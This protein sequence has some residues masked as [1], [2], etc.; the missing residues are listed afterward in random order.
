MFRRLFPCCFLVSSLFWPGLVF[1]QEAQAI[2]LKRVPISMLYDQNCGFCHGAG[3]V[4]DGSEDL[5]SC[6]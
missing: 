5:G 3:G 2:S 6:G 4:G 1:G